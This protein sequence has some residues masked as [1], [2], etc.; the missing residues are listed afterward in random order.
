MWAISG[1][2]NILTQRNLESRSNNYSWLLSLYR[3][4]IKM[5]NEYDEEKLSYEDSIYELDLSTRAI[6]ALRQNNIK[7]ILRVKKTGK[8]YC[9]K[10]NNI[11]SLGNIMTFCTIGS[12]STH[13]EK[14]ALSPKN[15]TCIV[16]FWSFRIALNSWLGVLISDN[17]IIF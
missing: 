16:Q 12:S 7:T 5:F 2:N 14:C 11:F 1:I 10:Y 15:R 3:G 8:E 4:G 13:K 6:R 17:S 9:T